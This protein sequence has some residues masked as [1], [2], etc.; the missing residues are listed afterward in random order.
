MERMPTED[1]DP[2]RPQVVERPRLP[3]RLSREELLDM[4]LGIVEEKTGYP[5]DMVELD[6]NLE[7]DLGI[8]SI[9]RIEVV[10]AML[11]M[12]PAAH[13]E[14]LTE[15]RSKL[16]TQPSLNGMLDLILQ[17]NVGDA[18]AVP[19]VAVPRMITRPQ[20][21]SL[22]GDN[23]AAPPAPPTPP[24]GS[25]GGDNS[26]MDDERLRKVEHAVERIDA[27]LASVSSKADLETLRADMH[28]GFADSHKATNDLIKWIVGT[29]IV[30]GVAGI[31]VMTFV[32]NNAVPK[33]AVIQPIVLQPQAIQAPP[34]T[35]AAAAAP[36]SPTASRP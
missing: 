26:G 4:L 2:G 11:Q 18:V 8:D 25:G 24:L 10:G 28:K 20:R 17:A 16:N 13:R 14:A 34:A 5:R 31:T 29:A 1:R 30:L 7:A 27:T 23:S 19:A 3:A 21:E 12:L 33:A 22:A 35:P 15:S 36:P 9:K 32:L 6:Q